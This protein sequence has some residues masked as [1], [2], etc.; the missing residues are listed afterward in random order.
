M[1]IIE[2]KKRIDDALIPLKYSR[3]VCWDSDLEDRLVNRYA[4]EYAGG[5]DFALTPA[6]RMMGGWGNRP[7]DADDDEQFAIIARR[8]F[9]T[10]NESAVKHWLTAMPRDHA[11]AI[12]E[13]LGYY[14]GTITYSHV[15]MCGSLFRHRW[16]GC[17]PDDEIPVNPD[18]LPS[19]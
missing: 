14:E 8:I 19:V 5:M 18:F 7:D 3:T 13:E 11:A 1:T 17:H 2:A 4:E 15:E 6:A 10:L 16:N 9:D 12:Y